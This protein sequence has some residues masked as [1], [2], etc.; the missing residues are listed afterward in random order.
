MIQYSFLETPLG[1][2]ILASVPEGVCY[3]GLPGSAVEDVKSWCRK[4]IREEEFILSNTWNRT[5]EKQ[6]LEYIT[7]KRQQFT[8]P[9]F[10][11]NTEFRKTVLEAVAQIP[12]G[13]TASYGDIAKKIRKPLASRAV[14]SAN[15]SN[16]LPLVY[17][18]HRVI[19]GDGKIGGY[20]GSPEMK[21]ALL[22]MEKNYKLSE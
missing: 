10:H 12:F 14:G 13:K 21:K 4:H 20:G 6:I 19:Q 7:G 9:V 22:D 1:R 2:I 11:L 15:A 5:A 18:C 17:P 8:F 16:P 3:I